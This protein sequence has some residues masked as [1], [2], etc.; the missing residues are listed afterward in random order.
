MEPEFLLLLDRRSCVMPRATWSAMI[1]D[2][3]RKRREARSFGQ[4]WF[5]R[6]RKKKKPTIKI[7]YSLIGVSSSFFSGR[8]DSPS[9]HL[10][11]DP[12]GWREREMRVADYLITA[13]GFSLPPF[14]DIS[15]GRGG[16]RD[17]LISYSPPPLYSHI[18][19][20]EKEPF[21]LS[22]RIGRFPL[23]FLLLPFF[24]SSEIWFLPL[25]LISSIHSSS[26]FPA[27][28]TPNFTFFS[29][30]PSWHNEQGEEKGEEEKLSPWPCLG[31]G[32]GLGLGCMM[33]PFSSW[34]FFCL[35]RCGR[36]KEE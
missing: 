12:S 29:F 25:S 27:R 18:L 7:G 36:R 31:L 32:L 5:S 9:I 34:C 33:G 30:R 4:S 26:S 15:L 16:G 6:T 3:Y 10:S 11:P 19:E 20:L 21:F 35:S 23:R 14:L 1:R 8:R 17:D 22:T 13:F 2:G 24:P 28:E